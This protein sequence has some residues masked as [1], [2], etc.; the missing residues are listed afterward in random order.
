MRSLADDTLAE[1]ISENVTNLRAGLI[2]P[3]LRGDLQLGAFK[4]ASAGCLPNTDSVVV[5]VVCVCVCL[6][7]LSVIFFSRSA[8]LLIYWSAVRSLSFYLGYWV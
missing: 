4:C 1:S 5:V 6:S 3:Y 7:L 2:L 8:N